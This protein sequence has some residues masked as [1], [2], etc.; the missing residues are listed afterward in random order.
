MSLPRLGHDPREGRDANVS[1][2]IEWIPTLG[3]WCVFE[4]GV[5]TAILKSADFVAADFADWHRSLG[6]V[7]IDCSSV[8]APICSSASIRRG[9]KAK[10]GSH[11]EGR[12]RDDLSRHSIIA[13]RKSANGFG[14]LRYWH[15]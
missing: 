3:C 5:I 13:P 11:R 1:P 12:V 9:N 4:T 10:C 6:K 14:Q 7:G 2:A 15:D 8:I